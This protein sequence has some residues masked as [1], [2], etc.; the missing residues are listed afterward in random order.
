[1]NGLHKSRFNPGRTSRITERLLSG[2]KESNQTKKCT[3]LVLMTR[4]CRLIQVLC[5]KYSFLFF[6]NNLIRLEVWLTNCLT[7]CKS[8]KKYKI[9]RKVTFFSKYLI[10]FISWVENIEIFIRAAHL[11]KFWCFQH[12]RWNIFGIHLK[13]QISSIY[14]MKSRLR[15]I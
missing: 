14:H 11:W 7:N 6:H 13:K 2:R 12:T 9:K 15:V 10:Y 4:S 5:H 8:S 3:S 1:M